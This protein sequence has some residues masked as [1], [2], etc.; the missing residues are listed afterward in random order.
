MRPPAR[1]APARR[2]ARTSPATAPSRYSSSR[3]RSQPTVAA[4]APPVVAS[5]Q[6][7]PEACEQIG[8]REPR[9]VAIGRE[10]LLGLPRLG[11]APAQ[12]GEE[13]HE[14]EVVDEAE[15]APPEPLDADDAD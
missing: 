3:C 6:A 15:L 5:D 10:Q 11:P 9:P 2:S 1:S 12:R 13:L 4:H 14:A 8:R 7:S